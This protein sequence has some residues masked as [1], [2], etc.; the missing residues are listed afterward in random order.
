MN[1]SGAVAGAGVTRALRIAT[2]SGGVERAG[3]GRADRT[4]RDTAGPRRGA[5]RSGV[6]IASHIPIT[7][8]A[9]IGIIEAARAGAAGIAGPGIG[10][11]GARSRHHAVAPAAIHI[12]GGGAAIGVREIAGVI[13]AP[14]PPPWIVP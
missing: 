12:P 8:A 14:W 4:P 13:A 10:P 5:A 11:G 1:L 3:R 2:G 6:D 9:G 7:A